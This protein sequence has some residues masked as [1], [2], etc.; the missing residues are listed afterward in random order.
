[1]GLEAELGLLRAV[2]VARDIEGRPWH[3]AIEGQ[4][5]FVAGRTGSGKN[6]WTWSLVLHLA[7]AWRAGLVRFYGCDPKRVELLIGRG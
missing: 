7:P 4:H 1:M 5:V 3:M 6:S 2:P